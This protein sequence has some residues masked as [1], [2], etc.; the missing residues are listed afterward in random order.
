MTYAA[1]AAVPLWVPEVLNII[2]LV[3][4]VF[5]VILVLIQAGKGGGLAGA[6]GGAG[7][8]SAFG[9][10]TG[11]AFTK[12]TIYTAAIWVLLVM[13]LI[14]ITQP[15]EPRDTMPAAQN[16]PASAP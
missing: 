6:L 12:I 1:W 15:T 10:R 14:K 9:A 13:F 16:Q 2:L 4:G 7:G 8:S 5:L 3:A 11:D